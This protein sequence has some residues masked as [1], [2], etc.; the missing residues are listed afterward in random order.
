MSTTAASTLSS[1]P[2]VVDTAGVSIA[3]ATPSS[4]SPRN[5]CAYRPATW[6]AS[7]PIW[8]HP[9]W[10]GK[11][12]WCSALTWSAATASAPGVYSTHTSSSVPSWALLD[13]SSGVVGA[14]PGQAAVIPMNVPVDSGSARLIGGASRAPVYLYLLNAVTISGASQAVVQNFRVAPAGG[15]ITLAR[16]EVLPPARPGATATT[17]AQGVTSY[18]GGVTVI[19]D[20]GIYYHTP[21]LYVYGTDSTG[22]VYEARKPWSKI[23]ATSYLTTSQQRPRGVNSLAWEFWTGTGYSPDPT[24]A[25][26][27]LTLGGSKWLSQGPLSFASYRRQTVVATVAA[28]SGI[29]YGQLWLRRMHGAPAQTGAPQVSLGGSGAYLGGTLQLQPLLA[30]GMGAS[31]TLPSVPYVYTTQAGSGSAVTL[32]TVWDSYTFTG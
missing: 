9:T 11:L 12:I 22:A 8:F 13:P 15:T 32:A 26:P 28:S 1:Q 27:I 6:A 25:A 30:G 31:A 24:R 20:G 18:T 4:S 19:F 23:G 2:G 7:A 10:T 29:S 16:E 3:T 5:G 21:F 17:S 14:I